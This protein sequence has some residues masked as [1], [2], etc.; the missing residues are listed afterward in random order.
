MRVCARLPVGACQ[1]GSCTVHVRLNMPVHALIFWIALVRR[2]ATRVWRC[3]LPAQPDHGLVPLGVLAHSNLRF[4]PPTL[5]PTQIVITTPCQPD[6]YSVPRTYPG[7]GYTLKNP[8]RLYPAI[9]KVPC[10]NGTQ[11]WPRIVL[12]GA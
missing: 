7:F 4:L 3:H 10:V 5:S 1:C 11:T 12:G 8:D 6:E 2:Q 9:G